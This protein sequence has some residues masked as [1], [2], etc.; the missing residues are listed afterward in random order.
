MGTLT[1]DLGDRSYPIH[2]T[3]D[4]P[5][6]RVASEARRVRERFGTTQG[7]PVLLVSDTNVGPLYAGDVVVALEAQ[8]FRVITHTIEA[9]EPSKSLETV[10]SLIDV[11][12]EAGA[13]QRWY[14]QPASWP[15][16]CTG[17]TIV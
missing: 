12:L 16:S 1:V 14:T 6:E 13:P 7:S 11:A 2:V 4:L 8:G 3:P 9:G 15:P 5:A 10:S 17:S